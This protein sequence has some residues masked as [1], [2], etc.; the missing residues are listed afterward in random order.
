MQA[1]FSPRLSAKTINDYVTLT[2]RVLTMAVDR[3]WLASNPL[4]RVTALRLPDPFSTWRAIPEDVLA[5]ILQ[6]IPTDWVRDAV[7]VLAYTGMRRGE[8]MG[9]NWDDIGTDTIRIKPE[10]ATGRT[11]KA[12]GSTRVIPLPSQVRAILDYH[13]DSGHAVPVGTARGKRITR[14]A[15]SN[16]W[17]R[18]MHSRGLTY[19][20]HDLRHTYACRLASAG[21]NPAAAQRVLGHTKIEITLRYYRLTESDVLDQVRRAT[22]CQENATPAPS[23]LSNR[24]FT[25]D[26]EGVQNE[27]ETRKP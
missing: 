18:Y 11:L 22:E 25:E 14:T 21:V 7:T 5:S 4:L 1:T 2:S 6:D 8:L 19:R 24:N 23:K 26:S 9:L 20:L 27:A 3:G 12:A 10:Q 17:I 13:R 15:L 16:A